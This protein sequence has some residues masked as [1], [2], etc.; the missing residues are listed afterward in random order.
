MTSKCCARAPI[1]GISSSGWRGVT[2]I[3]RTT[4]RP[5]VCRS[6]Y[7]S[8]CAGWCSTISRR[9]TTSPPSPCTR[10]AKSSQRRAPR[11]RSWSVGKTSPAVGSS[12]GER[13]RLSEGDQV[14]TKKRFNARVL[15]DPRPEILDP[16]GKAI[17]GA[18]ERIGFDQVLGVRAGKSLSIDLEAANR[19]E[20][21]R[22]L[23]LMCSRL[24]ANP[25]V[26]SFEI[27]HLEETQP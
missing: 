27:E 20:A 3:S 17:L 8:G 1:P 15:I 13:E 19:E 14:A 18:L 24:L 11:L 7:A 26:E 2:G 12:S 9:P 23:G 10:S 4:R 21:E 25:V 5:T 6:W 22:Q 16:Q